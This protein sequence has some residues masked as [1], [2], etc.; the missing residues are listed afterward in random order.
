MNPPKVVIFFGVDGVGKTTHA[1]VV[2]E[3]YAK[4]GY[5]VKRCWLRARHSLSYIISKILL[6]LG[7]RDTVKQGDIDILDSRGLPDKRTWSMLEFISVL[8]WILTRMNLPLLLGYVVVADR[9]LIDN[10]VFNRY[11]IGEAFTRYERI[12]LRMMPRQATLIHLD[13]DAD[14]LKRRR[15][16]DWPED[17][18]NFQLQQY[19]DM[20]SELGALSINT[21]DKTKEEVDEIITSKIEIRGQIDTSRQ[22]F[23]ADN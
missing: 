17:F 14:E 11:Y 9:Y 2:S 10:I 23:V 20:A 5:R 3:E 22:R 4:R 21:S 13:A 8:P 1:A 16:Q 15:R 12:L 7:Y 18:I 6:E 19:R